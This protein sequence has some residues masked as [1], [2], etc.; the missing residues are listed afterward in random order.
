MRVLF[1]STAGDGHVLPLLP[2]AQAFAVRGDDVLVAAAAS[3]SERIERLGLRFAQAGPTMGEMAT[4]LQEHRAG[5]ARPS[6]MHDRPAAFTGRFALIEA[7][8]RLDDLR[9]VVA[10]AR[11]DVLIHESAD[12]AAPIAGVAARIPTI[13][14]AFGLPIPEPALRR[15]AEVMAP[16]WR[17]AGLEPDELAGAY[18][19]SYVGICPPSFRAVL[20]NRPSRLYAL[21]PAEAPA[22]RVRPERDRPLVYATLGTT[23]NAAETFRTLLDAFEAIDCDVLMTIGRDREPADLQPIPANVR[24][25]RYVPQAEILPNCDAVVAH[26]GSGS[27]LAALAHGL[28]LVLV[29][30]GADQF[31]NADACTA[32]GVAEAIDPSELTVERL[33]EMLQRVIGDAAY[34]AAARAVAKE[35]AAMPSAASVADEIAAHR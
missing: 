31:A 34:G 26:A 3:H 30:Q 9:R 1:T 12:L 15:A 29:P 13:N 32:A 21:R 23:F 25:E 5:L 6:A 20:P 18:R 28:P 24:V 16:F 19:G 33:R 22:P 35:I 27:V 4:E 10:T 2:L 17:A 7:P 11:P 8:R 14:H